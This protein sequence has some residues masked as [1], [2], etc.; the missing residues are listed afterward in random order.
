M[1]LGLIISSKHKEFWILSLFTRHMEVTEL[2]T[3]LYY[4]FS[5]PYLYIQAVKFLGDF[6]PR[7]HQPTAYA[8]LHSVKREILMP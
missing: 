6:V 1:F 8:A 5:D 4:Y 2:C 7:I 3:S